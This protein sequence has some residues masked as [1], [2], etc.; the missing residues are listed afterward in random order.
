MGY[1]LIHNDCFVIEK[2]EYEPGEPV[3]ARFPWIATDTSSQ[4]I[5]KHYLNTKCGR[6][7]VYC[8]VSDRHATAGQMS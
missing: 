6:S 2:E 3:K 5:L 4:F 1:R 8:P 7:A